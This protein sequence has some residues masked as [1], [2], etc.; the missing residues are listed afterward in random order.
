MKMKIEKAAHME[1]TPL[2]PFPCDLLLRLFPFGILFNPAMVITGCGEKII[3]VAGKEAKKKLLLKPITKYF[4]LRRPKGIS[5][6]WKNVRSSLI[7][8]IAC[9]F[10]E[11]DVFQLLFRSFEM[12]GFD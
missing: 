10:N 1:T 9:K 4:R 3:E 2:S 11:G 8:L 7:F 12:K 5:F 6:T